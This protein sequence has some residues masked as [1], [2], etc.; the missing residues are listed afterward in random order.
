MADT[1]QCPPFFYRTPINLYIFNKVA[2]MEVS[3]LEGAQMK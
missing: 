1:T 2:L 3:W